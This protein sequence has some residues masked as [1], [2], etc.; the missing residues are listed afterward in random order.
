MSQYSWNSTSIDDTDIP[1][2]VVAFGRH[3]EFPM[4]ANLMAVPSLNNVDQSALYTYLRD[5]YIDSSF[6]TLVLQMLIEDQRTAH[7][8]RWNT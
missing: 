6:V 5:V 4:D 8:T 1:I 3:F 7:R 2:C